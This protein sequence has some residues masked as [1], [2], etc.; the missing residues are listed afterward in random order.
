MAETSAGGWVRKALSSAA[1][2][3]PN[4]SSSGAVSGSSGAACAST[5]S[6]ASA[7]EIS[8]TASLPQAIMPRL[9]AALFDEP[10]ALDAHAA[11]DG[12]DHVIDGQ[13]GDRYR[14]QRFHLDPG[15][16]SDLHPRACHDARQ[17]GVRGEFNFDLRKR[18][19]VTKRDE[20]VRA[21]CR[22]DAGDPRRAQNVALLGIALANNGK[23]LWRHD[24]TALGRRD[25][26]GRGLAGDID[27]RGFASTTEVTEFAVA[28]RHDFTVG[29]SLRERGAA[30]QQRSRRRRHIVLAHQALADQK[31][32]NPHL[33]QP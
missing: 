12:F 2:T 13:A 27:H 11:F 31:C 25:P 26:F 16:A 10:N 19:W 33:G 18:Q 7:T 5:W 14:G 32:R 15:L 22:L 23:R 9:A 20:F 4:A 30:R 3:R 6:S 1:S 28:T 17:L 8:A 24:D 21:L 29:T